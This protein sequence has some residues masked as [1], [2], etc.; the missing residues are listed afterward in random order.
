MIKYS[1]PFI[2]NFRTVFSCVTGNRQLLICARDLNK[3][4]G[5][6]NLSNIWDCFW[7]SQGLRILADQHLKFL[8]LTDGTLLSGTNF[9][10]AIDMNTTPL[11]CETVHEFFSSITE[12]SFMLST[13]S[14]RLRQSE[15]KITRSN[16][17]LAA[18]HKS[19]SISFWDVSTPMIDK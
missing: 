10:E 1:L 2:P 9:P 7:K 4:S 18:L 8:S 17:L 3:W 16:A 11:E 14:L 15:G 12:S 19:G 6:A 5:V 13:W